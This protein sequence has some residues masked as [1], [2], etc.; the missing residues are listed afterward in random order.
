MQS[1]AL[2]GAVN[3]FLGFGVVVDN[4]SIVAVPEASTW[5]MLILGFAVVGITS[6]RRNLSVAA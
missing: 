5:M 4:I 3:P 6:R 2:R 1:V